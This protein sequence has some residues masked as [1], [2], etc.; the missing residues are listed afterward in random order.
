MT[1]EEKESIEQLKS[2]R[3]YIIKHKEDVNKANDIEFYLRTAI[4]LIQKQDTE[5]NKLNK[6]I[7][8]MTDIFLKTYRDWEVNRHIFQ[9]HICSKLKKPES[10]EEDCYTDIWDEESCKQCIKEYFMK[11]VCK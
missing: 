9:N 4:N 10:E 7:D 6:V 5:I 2:W 11:E 8:R 1:D 3:E